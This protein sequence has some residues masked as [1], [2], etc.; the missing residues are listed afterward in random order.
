MRARYGVTGVALATMV[1]IVGCDLSVTNPG[2]VQDSFLNEEGA[3]PAVVQGA[4]RLFALGYTRLAL[5]GAMASL[6]ALP[7]GLFDTE[8]KKG[9]L[10]S[11]NSDDNWENLQEG[12]WVA[13]DGVRRLQEA[14]AGSTSEYAELLI[15]AGF[16]NR[17]LGHNMCTAVI[18]AGPE[19]DF[20]DYFARAEGYFT[21]AISIAG[22][23]GA[24]DLVD[25]A[26]AGRADVNMWQGDWSGATSDAGAVSDDF[27]FQIEYYDLDFDD[28]NEMMF[29]QASLPWREYT[30]WG[31][32]MEDYYMETGDP[33]MSWRENP[34]DPIT[35]V[36]NLPFYVQLKF[37][38]FTSP[39]T[40]AS[41]WEMRLIE[42]EDILVNSP[43]NFQAAVDIINTVRA[44]NISDTDGNPL[45]PLTAADAT[46]TW[47]LLKQ[48][49][50]IELWGES[51]RF[52]DLRRWSLAN[53]PG[54]QPMEDMSGRSFC[55]P[56]GT[57]EVST[58]TNSLVTITGDNTPK[59]P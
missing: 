53:R 43:S 54:S 46:E 28:A 12:R 41:G 55:F 44:R 27:V 3:F 32:F 40:L 47:S 59:F 14:G 35:M 15:L 26:Y 6:E 58:N 24:T 16:A 5:D 42:A 18:D 33:R 20:M 31:T 50:R 34:D 36:D 23:A 30:V 25:A 57:T 17:A 2:P 45:P 9:I 10:T 48:E 21:E 38:E 13:E 49:R 4:R 52:G 56:V 8:F 29:R 39:H 7:G 1:T 22:G 51:R 37:T 19:T 11:D